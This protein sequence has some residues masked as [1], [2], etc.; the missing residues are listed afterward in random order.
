VDKRE[1]HIFVNNLLTGDKDFG[2]PLLFVWQP[3]NL[4]DRLP[5]SQLKELD[6]NVYVRGVEKTSFPLMFWS[7]AKGDECQAAFG[8]LEEMRKVLPEFSKDSKYYANYDGPLF[9]SVYLGRYEPLSSFPG[10]K[11]S[12]RVPADIEKVLGA[13]AKERGFVGAYPSVE[14]D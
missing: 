14:G 13:N 12:S 3:P 10:L 7:P 9:K 2:R 1:G 8:T 4:C 5:N 11:Y 6:H